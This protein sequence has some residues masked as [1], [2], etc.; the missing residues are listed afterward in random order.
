MPV[1]HIAASQLQRLVSLTNNIW[2]FSLLRREEKRKKWSVYK[3]ESSVWEKWCTTFISFNFNLNFISLARIA[4]SES[5]IWRETLNVVALPATK[6]HC[7][8]VYKFYQK[9]AFGTYLQLLP[10][11]TREINHRHE[12]TSPFPDRSHLTKSA[13]ISSYFV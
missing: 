1:H 12:T 5:V 13:H 2:I 9:T 7:Q 11:L 10:E 8:I 6:S 4:Q 3:S